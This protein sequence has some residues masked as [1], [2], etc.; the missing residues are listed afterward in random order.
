MGMSEAWTPSANVFPDLLFAEVRAVSRRYRTALALAL[1]RVLD[2]RRLGTARSAEL[3]GVDEPRVREL[4]RGNVD[5]FTA[6]ELVQMLA[7]VG[8]RV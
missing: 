8:I 5:A 4:I 2:C 1:I 3:L 6:E 7:A